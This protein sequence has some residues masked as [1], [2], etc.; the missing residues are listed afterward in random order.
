MH[1]FRTERLVAKQFIKKISHLLRLACPSSSL[2]QARFSARD[3]AEVTA[4]ASRR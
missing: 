4:F 3:L 1:A 2:G